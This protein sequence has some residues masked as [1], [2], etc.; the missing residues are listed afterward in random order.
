MAT[1]YIG[2]EDEFKFFSGE[3]ERNI[4]PNHEFMAR[5]RESERHFSND[6]CS[7]PY[8]ENADSR[9]WLET[10]DCFYIDVW[11]FE[12]DTR[13]VELKKGCAK[14]LAGEMMRNRARAAEYG[15]KVGLVSTHYNIGFANAGNREDVAQLSMAALGPV[16]KALLRNSKKRIGRGSWKYRTHP[17]RTE[18]KS[19]GLMEPE[20][21]EAG[22]AF[23]VGTVKGIERL[24][25]DD[26]GGD[27]EKAYSSLPVI[28][29]ESSKESDMEV[30]ERGLDALVQTSRGDM[31]VGEIFRVYA[32]FFRPDIERLAT[33]DEMSLIAKF[34]S[35]EK[36]LETG[37]TKCTVDPD[38]LRT[39]TGKTP[40]EIIDERPQLHGPPKLISD[41]VKF[42]LGKEVGGDLKR[43]TRRINW[44]GALFE[45]RDRNTGKTFGLSIP[46]ED[47]EDYLEVE[48][49]RPEGLAEEGRARGWLLS[50]S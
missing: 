36:A 10:A 48:S 38:Y 15:G 22:I 24:L 50:E 42:S 45:Y 19:H 27:I 11:A 5:L 20:Q 17:G 8:G 44:N 40:K 32:D 35:G 33:D 21:L 41:A 46:P 25:E 39:A 18:F 34:A 29:K 3:L 4:E 2:A 37:E 13:V 28:V 6:G 23:L 1:E 30:L 47:A 16:Y 31:T 14:E 12:G 7:V 9:V 26:C 49:A 43:R